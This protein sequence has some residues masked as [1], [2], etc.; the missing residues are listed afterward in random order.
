MEAEERGA[1]AF[2]AVA[3]AACVLLTAP[4][5]SSQAADGCASHIG[6]MGETA[7][8]I[9]VT[10]KTSP[11]DRFAGWQSNGVAPQGRIAVIGIGEGARTISSE[12]THSPATQLPVTIETVDEISDLARLGAKLDDFL[13]RW[14]DETPTVLCFDSLNPLVDAVGRDG[15]LM[16]L[17]VITGRLNAIGAHGHFHFDPAIADEATASMLR[18]AFDASLQVSGD[19]WVVEHHP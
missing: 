11:D 19:Q 14:D 17:Q 1:P 4:R 13:T 2:P 7:D 8:T 5:G 18:T 12:S 3:D 6:A 15:L 9:L 10:V 16:F